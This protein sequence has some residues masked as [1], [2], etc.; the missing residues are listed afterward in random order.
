M[1]RVLMTGASGGIGKSMRA[2]LPAIYPGLVL[3]DLAPPPDLTPAETFR[4]ADLAVPAEIEAAC[5]GIDGIVHFGGHSVEGP[6]ETIL[7][8]NIV[9]CYNL[10]EAAR[11]A[12]VE[13]IVFA[14]SNHAV[15]FYPRSETI[16]PGV[17]VRPDTRYGVS[18]AFGEALGA[19][20]AYKHGI[21]V[22]ALRI[23]HFG[24]RPA[25]ERDLAIWLA[26]ADLVQLI[27]IG[28]EAPGLVFEVLY[29]I[30]DNARAWYDNT[31]ARELGYAPA[32]RAEDHAVEAMAAERRM[33]AKHPADA[34]YQ[35]GPFCGDDYTADLTSLKSRS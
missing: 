18:K 11:K 32:S 24:E 21:G 7:E 12:G 25:H 35:G 20:Y 13:R 4:R 26:P 5:Q 28:L 33:S 2:L 15:G 17:T 29:G 27:R 31:R 1:Q 30:S 16:P 34:F 23:G 6:W 19:M 3:S 22:T 10:F 14:S 9:G 8:A